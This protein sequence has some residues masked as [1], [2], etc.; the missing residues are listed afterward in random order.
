MDEKIFK[1]SKKKPKDFREMYYICPNCG[2]L[3]T[4]SKQLEGC[5]GGGMP[6]CY[7]EFGRER[8]FINYKR[9]NKKLWNE[10]NK[11]K[12]NMARLKTY[13]KY[14]IVKKKE[15]NIKC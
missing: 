15:K 3:S 6:Y 5:F 10:L 7:C 11:L 1:L 14:K 9:I 13:L 4:Y 8:V 2:E 12:S